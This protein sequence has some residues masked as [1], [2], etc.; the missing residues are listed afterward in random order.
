MHK[1]HAASRTM[2]VGT[3]ALVL[4]AA[5]VSGTAQAQSPAADAAAQ[6][7]PRTRAE[8]RDECIAFMKNHRWSEEAGDWVLKS[9]GKPEPRVP[10][11]VTTRAAIRAERDAFL[12]ANKWNEGT[13]A[14]EPLGNKPRDVS[15]LTRAQMRKETAA[16]MKTHRWDEASGT[17]VPAG[18]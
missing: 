3:A 5:C 8:V 14:W 7:C 1:Q 12:R 17:Y 11:G 15:T 10:E 13:G 18:K 4:T 2:S 9:T 16:F 6:E